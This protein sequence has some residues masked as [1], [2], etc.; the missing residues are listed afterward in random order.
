MGPPIALNSLICDR[1]QYYGKKPE[2]DK[3]R[4][5]YQKQRKTCISKQHQ[6]FSYQ[7]FVI[8]LY[9]YVL[10]INTILCFQI[11]F[12]SPKNC[13]HCF[14]KIIKNIYLWNNSKF[15]LGPLIALNSLIC[16]KEQYYGK[17]PERD[18]NRKEY[19]K[20]RK[21]CI[22]KQHQ[23]FSYQRFVILLY[24]YVLNINTIL[25][26]QIPFASPKNCAHCFDKIIKNIYLWN[27]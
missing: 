8:L 15:F 14:D 6:L 23:L 3:N 16:D 21:T 12:A 7:R 2:L 18:K 4:Q 19:Q 9:I 26:F 5:E 25:C 10:N 1:E 13:A 11:P 22:S 17:K 24:I 20:Q 27:K